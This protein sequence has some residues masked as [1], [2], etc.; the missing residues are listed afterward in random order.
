M[1]HTDPI[2]DY[3][4]RIK[5]ALKAKHRFVD[6]PASKMKQA[7][8]QILLEKKFI[9]G[10]KFIEDNRQ[11]KIRILL[12]YQNG[13][14]VI[15][16]LRRISKPGLRVYKGAKELPRV[17]GGLGIV[18]VSTSRGIMTDVQARKLNVGGEVIAY[19]W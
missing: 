9:A 12:R 18:I 17:L 6:I 7:I 10:Y 8:S 1:S 11:G 15:S 19:I 4:T 5:N 13:K 3:L 14:P 2:A 16:G